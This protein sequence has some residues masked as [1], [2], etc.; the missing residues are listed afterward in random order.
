M[1]TA[2]LL[3][4]AA[5]LAAGC[6]ERPPAESASGKRPGGMNPQSGPSQEHLAALLAD[7]P[8]VMLASD[9]ATNYAPPSWPLKPGDR[10]TRGDASFLRAHYGADEWGRRAVVWVVRE[11]DP[12][13][14]TPFGAWWSWE[15]GSLPGQPEPVTWQD[16]MHHLYHGH[17]PVRAEGVG[18]GPDTVEEDFAKMEAG[19]P[20]SLRGFVDHRS[21]AQDADY[22]RRRRSFHSNALFLDAERKRYYG[23]A[24][25]W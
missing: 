7:Y 21:H 17:F 13:T 2:I 3:L 11:N 16:R 6:H 10:V 5:A 25:S 22:S 4:A 8:R 23:P 1:R 24:A 15:H 20:P 14:A 9:T 19:L 12:A 18:H